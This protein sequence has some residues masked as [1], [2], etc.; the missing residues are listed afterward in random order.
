MEPN[1]E[2][3]VQLRT[4]N[5]EVTFGNGANFE[6]SQRVAKMLSS[7]S[8]IPDIFKNNIQNTMIA[9]EMSQRIGAS[10]LMVMQN[11]YIIH[12]KPSWS[13]T[14]IIS[15]IKACGRFSPLRYE[16]GTDDRGAFC[17]AW[18][19][20]K[21]T[22]DKLMGV[23]VDMTMATAE[24]WV[25]KAGS[26]WKTMPELMLRYR[27]AT[28]FGRTYCPDILMGMH[29]AEE[30]DDFTLMTTPEQDEWL[31]E[32]VDKSGLDEQKKRGIKWK[33]SN[34]MS[35]GEYYQFKSEILDAMPTPANPSMTEIKETIAVTIT[36]TQ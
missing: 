17:T 19:Y 3:Q 36:D 6:H 10:P 16:V 15:A 8:L 21:K 4:P 7:S 35:Q 22:N 25:A 29:T 12:G 20:D 9:L 5:T 32:N 31:T 13:S 27:A 26:K 28:F 24:G 18:A 1:N 34:G 11:L 33:M 23:R 14:F 2:I 30:I